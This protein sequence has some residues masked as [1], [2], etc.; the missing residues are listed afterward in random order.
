M[1]YKGHEGLSH[2]ID[3]ALTKYHLQL[4]SESQEVHSQ[5]TG[6][7]KTPFCLTRNSHYVA[8]AKA[9][10]LRV[11]NFTI[12][13]HTSFKLDRNKVKPT[14]TVLVH[15]STVPAIINFGLGTVL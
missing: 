5:M 1:T 15:L 7:G 2:Y 11:S 10:R 6:R 9:T 14:K 8:L 4:C 3:G 13:K 12:A